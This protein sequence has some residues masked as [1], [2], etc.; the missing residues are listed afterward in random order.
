M[1]VDRVFRNVQLSARRRFTMGCYNLI[2]RLTTSD[3][4]MYDIDPSLAVIETVPIREG[5]HTEEQLKDLLLQGECQN[6][7]NS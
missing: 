6:S 3:T 4:Q 7:S 2:K 1:V 5:E